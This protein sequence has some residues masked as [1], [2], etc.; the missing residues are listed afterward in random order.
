MFFLS[1]TQK[2]I[3][4]HLLC[5]TTYFE[6]NGNTPQAI[7][8]YFSFAFVNS[9]ATNKKTGYLTK[10]TGFKINTEIIALICLKS[11]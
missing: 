10:A 8:A 2:V 1:E 9:A 5:S 3:N 7:T 6:R 4:N 11:P